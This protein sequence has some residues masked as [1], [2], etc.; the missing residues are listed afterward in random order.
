MLIARGIAD[1]FAEMSDYNR[2]FNDYGFFRSYSKDQIKVIWNKK[3]L[4]EIKKVDLPTIFH[5]DGLI[6]KFEEDSINERY[7]GHIVSSADIGSGKVI[8]A[9]GAYDSSKGTLRAVREFD[10]NNVHYFPG[11]ALATSGTFVGGYQRAADPPHRQRMWCHR[12]NRTE[13]RSGDSRL[14]PP[15]G[16]AWYP[17]PFPAG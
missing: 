10:Y 1:L 9:D 4:N 5:K 2:D 14:L 7:F 13:Y 17:G 3:Y 12:C 6:D 16:R 8:G 15:C 11:D